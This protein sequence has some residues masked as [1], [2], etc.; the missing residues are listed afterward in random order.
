MAGVLRVVIFVLTV[1]EFK[2]ATPEH[3]PAYVVQLSNCPITV[4][5]LNANVS[6][7][8]HYSLSLTDDHAIMFWHHRHLRVRGWVSSGLDRPSSTGTTWIFLVLSTSSYVYFVGTMVVSTR[9][10]LCKNL[11]LV[12]SD[13]VVKARLVRGNNLCLAV[14]YNT[15]AWY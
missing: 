14:R 7:Y 8:C 10:A 12:M 1:I 15:V 13:N 11:E 4:R 6:H 5:L 9:S 2:Q 3:Y